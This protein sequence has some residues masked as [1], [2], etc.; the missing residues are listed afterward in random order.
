MTKEICQTC[1]HF[2]QHY[3]LKTGKV[4]RVFYGHCTF[5]SA[6]PV[7]PFKNACPNYVYG[8][9]DE[10]T[11]VTKKYLTKEL[12]HHFL[13]LELLPQIEDFSEG[14]ASKQGKA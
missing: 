1:T 3:S 7:R 10:D 2:H 12:L 11:F 5:A 4:V 9:P 6:K 13:Q 8:P 14:K